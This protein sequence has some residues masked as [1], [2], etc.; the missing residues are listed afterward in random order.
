ME[1]WRRFLKRW[2]PRHDARSEFYPEKFDPE[3]PV[4]INGMGPMAAA[5]VGARVLRAVA[6][7]G[8]TRLKPS[9]LEKFEQLVAKGL[10][11][12]VIHHCEA[13]AEQILE[14]LER[15]PP[16]EDPELKPTSATPELD[17]MVAADLQSRLSVAAFALEEGFDLELEYFDDDSGQWPRIRAS[18]DGIEGGDAADFQTALEL[19]DAQG[20]FVIPLKYVRWLMPVAPRPKG[21][22]P[23]GA[24]VL[25]FPG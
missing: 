10:P 14:W 11:E 18:L 21:D 20:D 5:F 16:V 12:E 6:L 13:E 15:P 22:P 24:D 4:L 1:S 7:R 17:I 25:K 19:S 3:R 8:G 9:A 2:G 23:K